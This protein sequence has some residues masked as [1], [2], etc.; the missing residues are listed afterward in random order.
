MSGRVLVHRRDSRGRW[1]RVCRRMRVVVKITYRCMMDVLL[2]LVREDWRI[3][4]LGLDGFRH[5]GMLLLDQAQ[6][7]SVVVQPFAV[8][9]G[10]V[11]TPPSLLNENNP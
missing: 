10:D 2:L 4:E 11:G 1:R 5:V 6:V 3:R 8:A 9:R 7:V